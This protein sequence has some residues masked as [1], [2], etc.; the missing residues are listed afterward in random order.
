MQF[1]SEHASR[2]DR[3][4]LG[5]TES[6]EDF[7]FLAPLLAG[8]RARGIADAF[9]LMG[10]AAILLDA[11]G[12]VLHVGAAAQQFLG[13]GVSVASRHL[14]GT[15]AAINQSLQTLIAA[16]VG[17]TGRVAD[18]V[19]IPRPGRSQ[20]S[21]RAI[22]VPDAGKDRMQLLKAVVVIADSETAQCGDHAASEQ[23]AA[24]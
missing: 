23:S 20:L 6:G 21:V 8:A 11:S 1:V 14:V 22:R 5:A 15:T 4:E 16:A 24:A 10:I 17:D 13:D 18:P 12:T 9:E 2:D 7:E 19:S 3:G